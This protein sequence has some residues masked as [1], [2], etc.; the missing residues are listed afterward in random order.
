[1]TTNSDPANCGMCSNACPSGQVCSGGQCGLQ[2]VGGSTKCGSACVSTATDSAN[3][4]ACSNVCA[5]GLVCSSGQC[6][7]QCAGGTTECGNAC[8]NLVNDPANCGA[9]NDVCPNGQVC[10]SK[11]CGIQCAGGTTLCG[12]ACVD[13]Q[14]DSTNCGACSK[15]CPSGQVCSG[16]ELRNQSSRQHRA[17]RR[18]LRRPYFGPSE[19]RHLRHGVRKRPELRR[20]HVHVRERSAASGSCAGNSVAVLRLIATCG[21]RLCRSSRPACTESC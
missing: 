1:M 2:C 14:I 4:G 11:N 12:T 7:L 20:R 21:R 16:R 10:S 17:V 19:L 5:S 6:G 18:S 8:V 3:C 13:T 9:C 15:V